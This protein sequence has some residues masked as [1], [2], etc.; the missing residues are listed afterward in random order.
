MVSGK[1]QSEQQQVLIASVK[2]DLRDAE[3]IEN[4]IIIS[5]GA[6]NSEHQDTAK[7]NEVLQVLNLD[8]DT[9]FKTQRRIKTNKTTRLNKPFDMI[10]FDLDSFEV[11][12]VTLSYTRSEQVW[13]YLRVNDETILVG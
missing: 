13:C 1:K 10:V 11:S 8:S 6:G 4:N 9:I 3:R 7:V 12:D 2:K 5:A